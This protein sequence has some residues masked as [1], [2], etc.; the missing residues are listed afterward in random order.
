MKKSVL[1]NVCISIACL[2][3]VLS[4]CLTAVVCCS[5][6]NADAKQGEG[7]LACIADA[8]KEKTGVIVF[9]NAE[10][11]LLSRFVS[12]ECRGEPYI[13]RVAAAAVVLNRIKSEGFPNTAEKVIFSAG[14]FTSVENNTLGQDVGVGDLDLS[15]QAVRQAVSGEDPTSGALYFAGETDSNISVSNVSFRAGGMV[16]GW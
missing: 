4:V 9:T 8:K 12:A 11:A 3:I 13:C 1:Y 10:I 2:L 7:A 15:V 14:A 5:G 6:T 16:F